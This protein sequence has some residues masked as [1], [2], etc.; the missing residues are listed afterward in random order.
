M[1]FLDLPFSFLSRRTTNKQT[2][3]LEWGGSGT[4]SVA[5]QEVIIV[6]VSHKWEEWL[7]MKVYFFIYN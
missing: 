6:L 2:N 1:D 3:L 5:K 4:V 7:K